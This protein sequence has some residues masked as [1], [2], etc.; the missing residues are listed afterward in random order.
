M[1][2]VIEC[3]PDKQSCDAYSNTDLVVSHRASSSDQFFG[4]V[5]DPFRLGQITRH[6]RIASRGFTRPDYSSRAKIHSAYFGGMDAPRMVA[7][8]SRSCPSINHFS[9]NLNGHAESCFDFIDS[10]PSDREFLK[11]VSDGDALVK[12]DNFWSIDNQVNE[13]NHECG[14]NQNPETSA[15]IICDHALNIENSYECI[16][17]PRHEIARFSSESLR[18]SHK[19]ILSHTTQNT[20][21]GE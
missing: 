16:D 9:I 19:A 5:V 4:F 18:V 6:A 8:G 3:D 21:K 17:N 15:E 12:E 1:S 2:N 20:G 7:A 11:W 13:I 14:P 10:I